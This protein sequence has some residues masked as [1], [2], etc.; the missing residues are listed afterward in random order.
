MV[1]QI[2]SGVLLAFYYVRGI[3]AWDS[4][5]EIT[6]EVRYGWALRLFHRNTASFVFV[7][8]F[9][10][11]FRGLI[12][13]SFYLTGAWLSG[14]IILFLTIA[15][16]FLGY[17]L[18]WGQMSF[19]GAT[20]IINLLRVLPLGKTLVIWLWGGFYVSNFTCTFFYALHFL[21]PFVILTLA[22]L[23]LILLHLTGSSAPRGLSSSSNIKIKFGHL[24]LYKDL[25]NLSLL[26]GFWLWALRTPDWAADPINFAVSDLSNSP[27]HIQP[28]WYF[29]HL[30]AVLRSIPNKLGGL[31]GFVLALVILAGLP[32]LSSEIKVRHLKGY[33]LLIWRFILTNLLLIWLGRQPVE[34][35]YISMGQV[36]TRVYFLSFVFIYCLVSRSSTNWG[37][38]RI[39]NPYFLFLSSSR[40]SV[41]ARLISD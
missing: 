28:E 30:Y 18:P 16:A 6:R 15:A 29:L 7:I 12:Q 38:T 36:I 17:V 13:A 37:I 39:A 11:F 26:W 25:V 20:V 41:S 33:K 2:F 21:V 23:H 40:N 9:I 14:W 3:L 27:L 22:G 8:L 5:V 1:I 10:H 31:V 35:P 4:V 34:A 32:L 24:F 19:W